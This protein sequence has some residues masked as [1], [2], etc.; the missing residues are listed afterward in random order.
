MPAARSSVTVWAVPSP[1]T[2]WDFVGQIQEKLGVSMR[3]VVAPSVGADLWFS[4]GG[5][6]G[7]RAAESLGEQGFDL[8]GTRHVPAGPAALGPSPSEPPHFSL[9]WRPSPAMESRFPQALT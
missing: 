7:P 9:K 6:Q 2:G 1:G 3:V 5:K 8:E 4:W